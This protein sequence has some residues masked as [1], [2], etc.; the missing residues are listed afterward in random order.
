MNIPQ[1]IQD[2]IVAKRT[3]VAEEK[4]EEVKAPEADTPTEKKEAP[5]KSNG[6]SIAQIAEGMEDSAKEDDKPEDKTPDEKKE[7]KP[8][9]KSVFE[10]LIETKRELKELRKEA[11]ENEITLMEDV[12]TLLAK[13]EKLEKA[14]IA[15]TK[16]VQEESDALLKELEEEYG[17]DKKG[18]DKLET[19]LKK[20]L[21]I[22]STSKE[23]KG[24]QN[25]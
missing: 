7:D 22:T 19:L 24:D 1:D 15:P 5:T 6:Q 3:P 10:D 23:D 12:K 25:D 2:K 9:K 13:V 16:E 14:G 4:K 18:F 21:G 8:K 17:L 20:R 11:T